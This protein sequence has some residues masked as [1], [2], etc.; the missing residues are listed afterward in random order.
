MFKQIIGGQR[1]IDATEAT[2]QSKDGSK[3]FY[4][5]QPDYL[6]LVYGYILS[7]DKNK[8]IITLNDGGPQ[9]P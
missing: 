3:T 8:D 1:N 4:S 5:K 2:C 7:G 6:Q 9:L